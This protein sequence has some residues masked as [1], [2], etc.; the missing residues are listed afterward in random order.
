MNVK[1]VYFQ[2]GNRLIAL[3]CPIEFGETTL[4]LQYID[5]DLINKY[6]VEEAEI[7]AEK[8]DT[9]GL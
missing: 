1:A 2:R 6:E 7:A 5:S 3:R 9:K 4:H 8:T